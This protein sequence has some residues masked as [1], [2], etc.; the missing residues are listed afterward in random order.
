MRKAVFEKF[1]LVSPNVHKSILRHFYRD[2]TGD[3]SVSS[4]ITEQEVDESLCALF[5]LEEP[6]LVYDLRVGNL[7]RSSDHFQIFWQKA[8]EFL[9]E[10]VG[11]AV[12][13]HRH[14]LVVHLAK[15]ISVRDF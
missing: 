2:L 11:T 14:S 10:G 7:G 15:A 8:K 6:D 12:D 5:E 9:E 3:Q 1:G 13:D 4:S